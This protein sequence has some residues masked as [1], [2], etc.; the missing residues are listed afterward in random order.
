[1]FH[2]YA[3]LVLPLL[4][5]LQ[6]V[7]SHR[8]ISAQVT[9]IPVPLANDAW[10]LQVTDDDSGAWERQVRIP[11]AWEEH[12]GDQFDGQ[13]V[14][15]YT[16]SEMAVESIERLMEEA[17]RVST[18]QRV[19]RL[20]GIGTVAEVRLNGTSLGEH[21]GAWTPWECILDKAWVSDG[22]NQLEIHVDEKVGHHTQGFLPIVAPHFGGIWKPV[23]FSLQP[24]QRILIDRSLVLGQHNP[25]G[26]Q[27]QFGIRFSQPMKSTPRFRVQVEAPRRVRNLS[28]AS[29]DQLTYEVG[30]AP[31]QAFTWVNNAAWQ[32]GVYEFS[33][34]VDQARIW[35]CDSPWLYTVTV[36][37]FAQQTDDAD[38]EAPLASATFTTGIRSIATDGHRLMLNGKA[39]QV[40]GL[41]NWGYSPPSTAPTLDESQMFAE[42]QLLRSLD[43][44]LM[45]FCLYLPPKPYLEWC[46]RMGVLAWMEYP[47]WH[48]Q[49][50][51][52]NL[53]ALSSE[54]REFTEYDRNHPAVILRSLTCETGSSANLGVIQELYDLVHQQVPGCVVE[55]DSSWISW[56]RVS[57]FWDDHPY[58]NN[59]T[60]VDTLEGLKRHIRENGAKPLILGEAIAADT[61]PSIRPPTANSSSNVPVSPDFQFHSQGA[62]FDYA[63]R[64]AKTLGPSVSQALYP[65]SL[66]YAALMRKYQIEVYRREVPYGGFVLSVIRDFPLAP[67]G[68]LDQFGNRK[69][70]EMKGPVAV[71][72]PETQII[73]E[74]DQDRRSFPVGQPTVLQLYLA[75]PQSPD[76]VNDQLTVQL[77]QDTT[78][79]K[80]T[81]T[82]QPPSENA[83]GLSKQAHWQT[84]VTLPVPPTAGPFNLTVTAQVDGQAVKNQWRLWAIP[85]A[86]LQHSWSVHFHRSIRDQPSRQTITNALGIEGA[87]TANAQHADWILAS[88]WD[89]ELWQQLQDGARVLMIPDGQA[90]SFVTR[91]HWFLRGGPVVCAED[92]AGQPLDPQL[93]SMLVDLQHFDLAGPVHSDF[94]FWE[95]TSPLLMLWD[96][97]D[98]ATVK[99]HG[100]A[101]LATVGQG[102]L[103]VSTLNHD[104]R[105]SAAGP[106]LLKRL[107]NRLMQNDRAAPRAFSNELINRLTQELSTQQLNLTENAWKLKQDPD[108][109]GLE[110]GW[111][112][113]ETATADWDDIRIDA[114]WEGQGQDGLDGWAWYSTQ[115]TIPADWDTEK[116]Y[117]SFTG[118]DDHYVAYVNGQRVGSAGDIE[119]RE[120]AF[121]RR[122]SYALP[123]GLKA[124]ETFT[125]RIEVYDWY[126]AGGIFRPIFLRTTPLDDRAPILRQ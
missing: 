8:P 61:W 86:D 27:I 87:A 106:Y 39:V 19:L 99:T 70:D 62:S 30:P 50:I 67:M 76:N 17:Q 46:D 49:L 109:Q 25:T 85:A 121:E 6:L 77:E 124:G 36:E 100:L 5:G 1:M 68:F 104:P 16:F 59:H 103:A 79:W 60:W 15:R 78:K 108:H 102:R 29:I 9:S 88:H 28:A 65:D 23:S 20:E 43:L 32:D 69:Y 118:V 51:P 82:W 74:T 75:T 92:F 2:R 57:D 117:L 63:T 115:V 64:I 98:I 80:R 97:H 33:L 38:P 54:Y 91:N 3:L 7:V 81:L 107:L 120:T 105:R 11:A 122:D 41:L 72:A 34:P 111:Q 101:W 89:R 37:A 10:T 119:A 53:E 18:Y 71:R 48:A 110:N 126:G 113:A 56:N 93:H 58:G 47:T 21:T 24:K 66:T 44:N 42:L 40:R 96:S 22:P 4:L 94:E 13:A 116:L 12:L 45:K 73:L 14:Y 123:S 84:P 83:D 90:S 112:L 125:L 26:D 52:S 114:H 35:N 95:Q 55:D 31:E